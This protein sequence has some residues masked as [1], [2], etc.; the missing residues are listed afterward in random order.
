MTKTC[1]ECF[2]LPDEDNSHLRCVTVGCDEYNLVYLVG[3]WN[4]LPRLSSKEEEDRI[5]HMLFN[6]PV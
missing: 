6:D 4:K 5:A 2:K 1:P 3:E